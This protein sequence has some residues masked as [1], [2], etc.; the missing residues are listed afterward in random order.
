MQMNQNPGQ[1]TLEQITQNN[2]QNIREKPNE[3]TTPKPM[4]EG[5][6]L[7][8]SPFRILTLAVISC[9]YSHLETPITQNTG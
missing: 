9:V 7:H 5:P 3:S 2:I 4:R 6:T 1:I 8:F